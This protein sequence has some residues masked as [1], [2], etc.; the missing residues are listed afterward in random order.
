MQ[1]NVLGGKDAL[2]FT[3]GVWKIDGFSDSYTVNNIM[4]LKWKLKK[5][6]LT[7]CDKYPHT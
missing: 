4:P 3:D 1:I 2:H 5:Y 7:V 6:R